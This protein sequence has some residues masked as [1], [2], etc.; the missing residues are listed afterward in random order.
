M[1]DSYG[2]LRAQTGV[3]ASLL[4]S[5][6]ARRRLPAL[7]LL[8]SV[9]LV[10]ISALAGRATTAVAGVAVGDVVYLSPSGS[11][12]GIYQLHPADGSS[13][14]ILEGAE[15]QLP[16]VSPDASHIAFY[17]RVGTDT[18]LGL[19]VMDSDGSNATQLVGRIPCEDNLGGCDGQPF[20]WGIHDVEW[21]P[22]GKTIAF[23][24]YSTATGL[25]RI[26]TVNVATSVVGEVLNESA[27]SIG[28]VAWAPDGTRLAYVVGRQI[29]VIG[30]DGSND[31]A[32]TF[33]TDVR[34]VYSPS[35]SHDGDRIYFSSTA[36]YAGAGDG[37]A[38]SYLTY[39]GSGE[40]FSTSATSLTTLTSESDYHS[41]LAPRVS[42]DD[43][44]IYFA[45]NGHG[46]TTGDATNLAKVSASAGDVTLLTNSA[47]PL[48]DP[49]PVGLLQD[50]KL[51]P[52]ITNAEIAPPSP[53]DAMLT[54]ALRVTLSSDSL[55][56]TYFE[57]G[58]VPPDASGNAPETGVQK[59]SDATGSCTVSYAATTP[60]QAG[61]RLLVRG[62]SPDGIKSP[63]VFATGPNGSPYIQIPPKPMVLALGDS[64]TS[65]HHRDSA[66]DPTICN[67]ATYGYPFYVQRT[68]Q[69][70]LPVQWQL[71]GYVNLARGGFSTKK[72][73][74]GGDDACGKSYKN[75]SKAAQTTP[76]NDA[77]KLLSNTDHKSSWN[78]VVITAGIDDTNWVDRVAAIAF[79]SR[80]GYDQNYTSD[81]C[82][83][84]LKSWTGY[85]LDVQDEIKSR[86]LSIVSKLHDADGGAQ[87]T[88]RGYFNIAGTGTGKT[89]PVPSVC[90]IPV[91]QAV[92]GLAK[93]TKSAL[94]S[95]VR[96]VD[97]DSA[98]HSQS[99]LIQP[100][101][102]LVD[103]ATAR[104]QI[105]G[106]QTGWPHPN[107][108]GAKAMAEQVNP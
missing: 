6:S 7:A 33:E 35:W 59:C 3:I 92:D 82:A 61:W 16:T 2:D 39:A 91:Q 81:K 89:R 104:L 51:A 30:T 78:R 11:P 77:V 103:I 66:S 57:Y 67:D 54:R 79:N 80:L 40:P 105:K 65:G 49:S 58:W 100:F 38:I 25:W 98:M 5:K 48:T 52:T 68:I 88:W 46:S 23:V 108:A 28:S 73:L 101:Y 63:W 87:I 22:D 69:S 74:S 83:K 90:A 85:K 86:V 99:D 107:S 4:S 8:L 71:G 17:G 106:Y 42:A 64:I 72:V 18:E 26:K 43:K 95:G 34:A 70:E 29:K 24:K 50:A 37:N 10:V 56:A 20:G 96:F 15:I 76:I 12:P 41:D 36:G 62:V 44:T 31:H 1:H 47:V 32:L 97:T 13:S 84:D 102:D 21:S 93:V 27:T 55:A 19:Y 94:P 75:S 9:A 14:L 60:Q 45:T 53:K